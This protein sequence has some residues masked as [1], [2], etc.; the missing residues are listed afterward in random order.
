VRGLGRI[1]KEMGRLRV[2][3][4]DDTVGD[5]NVGGDDLGAYRWSQYVLQKQRSL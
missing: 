5:E 2:D 4:V 1:G 3:N